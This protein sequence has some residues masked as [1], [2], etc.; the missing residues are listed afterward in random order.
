MRWAEQ[1]RGLF[2]HGQGSTLSQRKCRSLSR[3]RVVLMEGRPGVEV[4]AGGDWEAS[5]GGGS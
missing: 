2:W 4:R 1:D 5:F 3:V